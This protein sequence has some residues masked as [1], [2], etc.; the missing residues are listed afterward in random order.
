MQR[1]SLPRVKATSLVV[2]LNLHRSPHAVAGILEAD[3]DL[4]AD[5]LDQRSAMAFHHVEHEQ[6]AFADHGLSALIT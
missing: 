4:V 2:L 1:N 6:D 3:H 5:R